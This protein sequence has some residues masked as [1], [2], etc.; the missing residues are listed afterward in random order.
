MGVRAGQMIAPAAKLQNQNKIPWGTRTVMR[1]SVGLSMFLLMFAT[2]AQESDQTT[3]GAKQASMPLVALDNADAQTPA[4]EMEKFEQ[5]EAA[6]GGKVPKRYVAPTG[7]ADHRWGDAFAGFARL[8][9]NPLSL[10]LAYSPGLVTQVDTICAGECTLERALV[11]LR[12]KVEGRGFHVFSEFVVPNQGFR[13]R[14]TGVLMYPVTYQFCGGWH[15]SDNKPRPE[16]LDSFK[17]CGVRLVFRSQTTAEIATLGDNELTNYE[18]I[19][20]ELIRQY[21]RPYGH[22]RQPEVIIATPDGLQREPHKRRMRTWRWC[23]PIDGW[24]TPCKASIVL[25]FS[26]E[27]GNGVI[28]FS[29]PE[30][31]Q[32]AYIRDTY[33][34]GHDPM[35]RFMHG[36]ED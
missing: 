2:A 12:Q 1:V 23:P 11:T 7:F 25:G 9:P 33:I 32:F 27:S 31:W 8:S 22:V 15:G 18:L 28:L 36:R 29:T 6:R 24:Q 20:F 3:A 35:F 19:L 10:Q 34:E 17:L 5:L 30:A 26:P 13:Y 16:V 14:L 4:S 21:G